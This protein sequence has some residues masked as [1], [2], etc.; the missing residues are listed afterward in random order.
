MS[1]PIGLLAIAVCSSLAACPGP[2]EVEEQ[3]VID[4]SLV[5]RD[6]LRPPEP[7]P[8][9][10]LLYHPQD[11]G[12]E[13]G[14]DHVALLDF[15]P[16]DAS[17]DDFSGG[18]AVLDC[19][20]D[21]DL[22]L[23]L[24]SGDGVNG[25]FLN[26]GRAVFSLLEGSGLALPGEAT[27]GASVADFDRD[28]DP[29]LLLLAQHQP[30]RLLVN[31]GGCRF[32]DIASAAGLHD[33]HRS[34]HAAWVDLN[35]DGWLDLYV[36]NWGD[37][38][39]QHLSDTLPEEPQ[40]DRLWIADGVGRFHDVSHLLPA[41]LAINFG[42]TSG[43]LDIDADGD[44]D[45]VQT[46]D[47]G[48]RFVANRLFRNDGISAAGVDLVD[49]T[50]E[51]GFE[52]AIDGMGL[53]VTDLDGDGDAD[54]ANTGGWE[55]VFL[56]DGHG[57][58]DAGSALGIEARGE[59][60]PSWGVVA[61]D[62]DADGD[63]DLVTPLSDFFDLGTGGADD[64]GDLLLFYLNRLDEDRGVELQANQALMGSAQTW[65]TVARADLNGDGFEDLVLS[66]A[67]D[68]PVLL[69]ANPIEGRGVV[70]VKLE[71]RR[72]NTEGRGARV[73]LVVGAATQSRWPGAMESYATGTPTWMS[74]GL[75]EADEAGPLDVRW[76]SGAWQRVERVRSGESITLT[77][78]D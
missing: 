20:L 67:H 60:R 56:D 13:P 73:T 33:D 64:Y 49:V 19:D 27:A 30:N 14:L 29:D 12:E 5:Q 76:P 44:L 38:V 37:A 70:Q 48:S 65:R 36:A 34:L 52:L 40:P 58:V 72:S 51:R 22:D 62:P 32:T 15:D 74:F 6:L 55:T 71:G 50:E 35:R 46:N 39:P 75:D 11:H 18:F 8:G 68:A 28:G 78:P 21:G 45:L 57:Y 2:E 63:E 66:R 1:R 23:A 25:L 7:L 10:P 24:T 41:D 42:M 53:A 26:D 31:D 4:P 54:L 47:K 16:D 69:L 77:E 43:F 61:F 9:R 17:R 3:P 59:A